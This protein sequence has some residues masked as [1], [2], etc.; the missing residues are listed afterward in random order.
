MKLCTQEKNFQ[1]ASSILLL[2]NLRNSNEIDMIFPSLYPF[3]VMINEMLVLKS[4]RGER[5]LLELK[6]LR[7]GKMMTM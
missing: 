7:M 6:Q 5:V 3:H 1:C 4:G 2:F